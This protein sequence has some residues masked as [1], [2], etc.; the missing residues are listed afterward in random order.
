METKTAKQKLSDILTAAFGFAICHAAFTDYSEAGP[1]KFD[2]HVKRKGSEKA[3]SG[4]Y[5]AGSA[6]AL[7]DFLALHKE[8]TAA[9]L[10]WV[11]RGENKFPH[12]TGGR[13]ADFVAAAETNGNKRHDLAPRV[14]L[15]KGYLPTIVDVLGCVLTDCASIEG[16][17]DFAEWAENIGL[18]L[19]SAASIREA[20]KSYLEIVE[21]EAYLRPALGSEWHTAKALAGEL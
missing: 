3:L 10:E 13:L 8:D 18:E 20:Q 21:Q 16:C 6:C 5:K 14:T 7:A 9:A 11:R 12:M 19:S 17:S 2:W 15:R 4:T 1:Q